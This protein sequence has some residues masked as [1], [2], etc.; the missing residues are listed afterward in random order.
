MSRST[1]TVIGIALA[2]CLVQGA[3]A[4]A[5]W[6]QPGVPC[7]S[8]PPA[9]C[10]VRV[11]SPSGAAYGSGTLVAN[12]AGR[13]YVLTCEHVV[14][15]QA[16]SIE[17]AFAGGG[18]YA[19][20]LIAAD[21]RD[22]LALLEIAPS[23]R[24]AMRVA[25]SPAS[26]VLRA[27]G[28]GSAGRYRSVTVPLVGSAIPSNATSPSLRIAAA[29]RSGDSGG[30]VT[31]ASGRLVGVVWGVRGGETYFTAGRPIAELLASVRPRPPGT[32]EQST[33]KP[34]TPV[35][36]LP[37]QQDP[38]LDHLDG[39]LAT[40]HQ[41]I[42]NLDTCDCNGCV[43][44]D[45]LSNL[46]TRRDLQRLKIDLAPDDSPAPGPS[47]GGNALRWLEMAAAAAGFGGPVGLGLVAAAAVV[48]FRRRRK[49]GSG[50]GG[51]R[52][53]PFPD[54]SGSTGR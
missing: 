33:T 13:S 38:A 41:S 46:A 42:L 34:L 54:K 21:E 12:E 49:N 18:R 44:R 14:T 40:I 11:L 24:P 6:C 47:G 26:G 4:M 31:D 50:S 5:T 2:A 22:D 43:T 25:S 8:P 20:R 16:N 23:G 48:R 10:R 28:F 36:P 35:G 52:R 1:H 45:D 39:R 37:Q 15:G 19:A 32:T 29:V 9:V 3:A 53:D 51:P 30:P 27:G 17:V 7:E